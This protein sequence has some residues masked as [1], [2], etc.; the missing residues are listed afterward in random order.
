MHA[1]RAMP[2]KN[3]FWCKIVKTK[4]EVL[5]AICDE[6]LVGRKIKVENDFYIHI[7]EDFYKERMIDESEALELMNKATILNIFGKKIVEIAAK[8]GIISMEN[9]IYFNGIPHAQFVKI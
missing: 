6:D 3:R 1:V 4:T 9:V 8:N 2:S 5:I 7:K